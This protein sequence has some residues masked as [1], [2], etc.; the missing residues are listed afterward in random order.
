ME[1]P[2]ELPLL[3]R[4]MASLTRLTSL[5][6]SL[7]SGGTCSPPASDLAFISDLPR[8]RSLSVPL[9][10]PPSWLPRLS[11]LSLLELSGLSAAFPSRMGPLDAL[12]SLR[13]LYLGRWSGGDGWPRAATTA[14]CPSVTR[15]VCSIKSPQDIPFLQLLL[16]GVQDAEISASSGP[17]IWLHLLGT[18]H[19]LGI[20]PQDISRATAAI[21]APGP[22]WRDVRRLSLGIPAGF[23][24]EGVQ[25]LQRLGAL[26]GGLRAL[27]LRCG[28]RGAQLAA[29]LAASPRLE[30]LAFSDTVSDWS[31]CGRHERLRALVL[32]G[33]APP[34]ATLE[35]PDLVQLCDA[36]PKLQLLCLQNGRTAHALEAGLGAKELDA[37]REET[38]REGGLSVEAASALSH[39]L[40]PDDEHSRLSSR[41]YARAVQRTL[42]LQRPAALAAA[43]AEMR[44]E[45]AARLYRM[46]EEGE[47]AWR[48]MEA[49][50]EELLLPPAPPP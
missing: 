12:Q 36:L 48:E 14:C 38:R 15:L 10:E 8:L 30:A 3:A 17:N 27:S 39:G 49:R 29:L 32:S 28:L 26:D 43:A 2:L 41:I 13:V 18:G 25:L 4:S 50:V 34:D 5:D 16:P 33:D 6:L 31:G 7:R 42:G 24:R 11:S 46:A 44:A 23:G 35:R 37:A 9:S 40:L 1:V 45:Q 21:S 20:S 47:I 19:V 22:R